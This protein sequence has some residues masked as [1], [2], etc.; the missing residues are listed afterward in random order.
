MRALRLRFL[1][2]KRR[3]HRLDFEGIVAGWNKEKQEEIA[4]KEGKF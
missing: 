2:G 4:K 1:G 3:G